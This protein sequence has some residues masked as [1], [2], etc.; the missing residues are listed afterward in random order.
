MDSIEVVKSVADNPQGF[1]N[2]IVD[3]ATKVATSAVEKFN[4]FKRTLLDIEISDVMEVMHESYELIKD[5]GIILIH[6]LLFPHPYLLYSQSSTILF[7]L[8]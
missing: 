7:P 1:L 6:S 5:I 3:L 4:E 2:D 8:L